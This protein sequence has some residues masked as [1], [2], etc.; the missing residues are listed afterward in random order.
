M[1]QPL[2]RARKLRKDLTDTERFVWGKLRNRR[3]AQFKFR[4]Q[5]PLGAFIVDFICFQNRLIVELDGGQHTLQREYDAQR[6]AWLEAQG[7]QLI[8]F[9]N[10]DVLTD[11]D[12]VEEA[13]WQAL[14]QNP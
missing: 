7:F 3:F 14:H 12:A 1:S 5:V 4:R 2:D 6:T 8:R 10:H 9:W 11:W 13:I